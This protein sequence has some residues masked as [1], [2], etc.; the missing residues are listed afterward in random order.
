[1]SFGRYYRTENLASLP[2]FVGFHSIHLPALLASFP[3]RQ[4]DR[5]E[6]SIEPLGSRIIIPHSLVIDHDSKHT[7]PNV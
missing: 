6:R 5:I 7:G 3:P 4:H 1:M 2:L